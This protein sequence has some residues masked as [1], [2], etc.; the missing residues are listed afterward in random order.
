MSTNVEPR[1]Y[2]VISSTLHALILKN[3]LGAEAC[4]FYCNAVTPQWE[5]NFKDT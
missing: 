5:D 2:S 1:F 4:A 3:T